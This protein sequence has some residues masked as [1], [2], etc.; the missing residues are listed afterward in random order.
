MDKEDVL[1]KRKVA[2]QCRLRA[3]DRPGPRTKAKRVS[4]MACRIG[5]ARPRGCM[6]WIAHSLRMEINQM[7]VEIQRVA[8][9][10]L[11]R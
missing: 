11:A 6:N 10:R 7:V 2:L 9:G 8:G 3:S 1:K 5:V 4:A